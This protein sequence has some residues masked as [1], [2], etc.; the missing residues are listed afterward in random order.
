MRTSQGGRRRR[1]ADLLHGV[2]VLALALGAALPA[3]G[4]T[5]YVV[6]AWNNLG[7][8][9]MDSDYSV[10][11]IL[12]PYNT[13][14]A[15]VVAL[16]N[17][18][19]AKLVTNASGFVA[20]YAATADP[21]GSINMTSSGK[22]N[23]WTHSAK[24]YGVAP[25]PD[26]GLPVPGPIPWRMPGTNNTPQGMTF[27][28]GFNWFAAYGIPITPYDDAGRPNQ[29][30]MMRVQ[31]R[32]G[33][34]STGTTD[35]VLP[36]SDEMD[37]K[38]C[39]AS[40]AGPAARPAAGWIGNPHPGRDYRL[41]ILRLHDDRQAGKPL[42]AAALA[43]RRFSPAGLLATVS[44]SNRPIL[45]ASCHL[46]EAL[47]DTGFA[48]IPPL[49]RAMH[50][51]HATV[52]DPRTG[53][54]LD[55]ADNRTSCYTCHPGSVTRC[56]R[57]AMGRAVGADGA[58]SMQCQ[59]CHGSLSVVGAPTRTGWLD[60]PNCQACHSGH[61]TTNSGAIRFDTAFDSPGHLRAA[62]DNR[63]ATNP[64][65]PAAG[66][67]LY[68]FSRGHGGLQCSACHGSTHAE[69]PSSHPND[70]V[71]S[72]ARQGHDGPMAECGACHGSQSLAYDGGPHGMHPM[73]SS[74]AQ[75]HASAARASSF[76]HCRTCHGANDRGTVLSRALGTRTISTK[77]GARQYWKGRQIGCYDCHD[78]VNASD[79]T[80]R[81]FPAVTGTVAATVAG[82]PVAMSLPV[83]AATPRIVTQPDHG[84]VGLSGST[85]T[86]HPA[87]GYA[88]TDTFTFASN[89]GYNDSNLATGTVT[90]TEVDTVGDGV[91]DWW[92]AE[93][94]GSDGT[95]TNAVSAALADPDGDG[96]PNAA[97]R[98]A[99]T[100]PADP[101]S[102]L[103]MIQP[104]R[105]GSGLEIAFASMLGG[106]Y[107]IEVTADP[108]SDSWA[109]MASNMW[110][111]TDTTT[112]G[113]GAP[114]PAGFYRARV[115]PR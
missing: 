48:G 106:L 50:S 45:C 70:N 90:V 101:G 97:E 25:A 105:T 102:V 7:M 55:A 5:N 26:E 95:S 28:P 29:Y 64:D 15:Q 49:T 19:S 18:N 9:C 36:V 93:H 96:A 104:A 39:H 72:I 71:A 56:L 69:F 53:Q 88:G 65:T 33:T 47:P 98:A 73:T 113:G 78:G 112:V 8:H 54:S 66:I 27:E 21:E 16:V 109:V 2:T 79:P 83:G 60:E 41:N 99:G 94:F 74:W 11:S 37:C 42:Y 12:P 107:E 17:G 52:N 80:S 76:R 58:M 40:G 92:R 89:N 63:F 44:V 6:L 30:P 87:L 91:P 24:V 103:R 81:G 1:G 32:L 110:G 86:Y 46:S 3:A 20:T 57:G 75:N 14:H 115:A 31:A 68:R 13:V 59:S 77:F 23:F 114:L 108:R 111:R 4:A 82:R 85:A 43:A 22:G 62:A 100:D 10:F 84:S 51:R 61:A 35:I 67:S 38:L 34:A